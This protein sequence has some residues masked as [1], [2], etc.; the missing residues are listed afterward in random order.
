MAGEKMTGTTTSVPGVSDESKLF[1]ALAYLLGIVTGIIVFIMKKDDKYAKFHAMQSILLGVAAFVV[2]VVLGIVGTIISF[3]PVIG[4]IIGIFIAILWFIIGLGL[5]VLWL[6]LMWRAY[7]GVKWKL[8][9]IGER[10]EKMSA[11]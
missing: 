8:P 1:G 9:V 4:W 5:F 11:S 10:A 7:N 3:V 2:V 6:L